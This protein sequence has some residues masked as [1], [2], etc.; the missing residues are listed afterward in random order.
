[1]SLITCA[2]AAAAA[3]A[4][5][6]HL[7]PSPVD[8]PISGCHISL[9]VRSC[10]PHRRTGPAHVATLPIRRAQFARMLL[11]H[12]DRAEAHRLLNEYYS[13]VKISEEM[14]ELEA[15]MCLLFAEVYLSLGHTDDADVGLQVS[16]FVFPWTTLQQCRAV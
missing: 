6:P 13:E 12:G 8:L 14:V 10:P 1:M 2:A 4:R 11:E 3:T 16:I 15:E 5:D 9:P 7:V